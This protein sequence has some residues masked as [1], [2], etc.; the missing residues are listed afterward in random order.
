MIIFSSLG[1]MARFPALTEF[2]IDALQSESAAS[3]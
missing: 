1:D 2:I 3:F